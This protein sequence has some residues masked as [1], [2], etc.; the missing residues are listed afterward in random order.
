MYLR[1]HLLFSYKA[2]QGSGAEIFSNLY[3]R[4]SKTCIRIWG[5]AESVMKRS[6][7]TWGHVPGNIYK[8]VI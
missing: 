3:P 8:S 4:F 2:Q 1:L 7:F 6:H 5:S